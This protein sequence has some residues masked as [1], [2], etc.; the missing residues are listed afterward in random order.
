MTRKYLF[1]RMQSLDLSNLEDKLNFL[2]Y[3]L[4]S[5]EGYTED[6][7]ESLKCNF[8]HFKSQIKQ[9][10]LRA[11]KKEDIFHKNNHSWLEGTFEIPVIPQ[12][13]PRRP[14][15]LLK[16]SSERTKRRKTE[17]VR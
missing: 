1:D 7:T 12:P 2:K 14:Y 8:A 13:W 10:W 17:E 15:K 16:T 4:K 11:Y 6:Q 9:R 3:Q 5:G